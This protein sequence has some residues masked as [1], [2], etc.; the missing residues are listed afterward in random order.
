MRIGYIF[1][2]LVGPKWYPVFLFIS[3]YILVKWNIICLIICT[4]FP[5]LNYP[6]LF[7]THLC[8]GPR[9]FVTSLFEFLV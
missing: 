2:I 5:F 1:M 9:V 7:F 4:F 3:V 8:L 6:F